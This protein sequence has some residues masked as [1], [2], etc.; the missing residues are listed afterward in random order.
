MIPL[1]CRKS[2]RLII[3]QFAVYLCSPGLF[4]EK[5]QILCHKINRFRPCLTPAC[6]LNF[7]AGSAD[8]PAKK[9]RAGDLFP[10]ITTGK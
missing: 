9:S 1:N 6:T 2:D 8:E 5:I 3:L 7:N 10:E 4:A